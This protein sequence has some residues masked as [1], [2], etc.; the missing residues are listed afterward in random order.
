MRTLIACT[1]LLAVHLVFIQNSP[2]A[3]LY[4]ETSSVRKIASPIF[5]TSDTIN[6]DFAMEPIQLPASVKPLPTF[7]ALFKPLPTPASSASNRLLSPADPVKEIS[8]VMAAAQRP[9]AVAFTTP[10]ASPQQ[11]QQPLQQPQLQQQEQQQPQQLQPAKA[12]PSTTTARP[13]PQSVNRSPS[14]ATSLPLLPNPLPPPTPTPTPPSPPPPPASSPP[15]PPLAPARPQATTQRSTP[16]P[17]LDSKTLATSTAPAD[18][19]F[20]S[21]GPFTKALLIGV[22]ILLLLSLAFLTWACLRRLRYKKQARAKELYDPEQPM[23]E[24]RGMAL[25]DVFGGMFG[26]S[27]SASAPSKDPIADW[28]KQQQQKKTPTVLISDSSPPPQGQPTP[29]QAKPSLPAL[30]LVVPGKTSDAGGESSSCRSRTRNGSL[31]SPVSPNP[32]AASSTSGNSG[33]RARNLRRAKSTPN[34]FAAPDDLPLVNFVPHHNGSQSTVNSN[35]GARAPGIRQANPNLLRPQVA[36][37]TS[38]SGTL[39]TGYPS[40]ASSRSQ[41]SAAS[42]G[43][44][45]LAAKKTLFEESLFTPGSMLSTAPPPAPEISVRQPPAVATFLLPPG[46]ASLLN[47]QPPSPSSYYPQHGVGM[48]H[49]GFTHANHHHLHHPPPP[50]SAS[51]YSTS[52]SASG[53]YPHY[54]PYQHHHPYG[55][56]PPMHHPY[57]GPM[58]PYIPYPDYGRPF[59]NSLYSDAAAAAAVSVSPSPPASRRHRRARSHSHGGGQRSSSSS[60]TSGSTAGAGGRGETAAASGLADDQKKHKKKQSPPRG[61]SR[62]RSRSQKPTTKSGDGGKRSRSRS[63]ATTGGGKG[64]EAYQ[65]DVE[66]VQ[67]EKKEVLDSEYEKLVQ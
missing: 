10:S 25:I 1:N 50:S 56:A 48:P 39:S 14:P 54:Y 42:S 21:L 38:S 28:V 44:A 11:L 18:T 19:G 13:I 9:S 46:G 2:V 33:S 32:S 34:L 16:S 47:A 52:S 31:A 40:S 15:P 41:R 27:A 29:S 4:V 6:V 7:S 5:V 66:K 12:A 35:V 24:R 53:G 36:S 49:P 45:S 8:F 20:G 57:M 58:P 67:K 64:K 60:Q 62:K 43:S 37:S 51:S 30:R 3:A 17:L 26:L 23:Q 55:P 22:P 65:D 61:R 63:R 59:M